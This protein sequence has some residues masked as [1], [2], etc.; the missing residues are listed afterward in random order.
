M[1]FFQQLLEN[2]TRKLKIFLTDLLWNRVWISRFKSIYCLT[3]K[4]RFYDTH[5]KQQELF[6]RVPRTVRRCIEPRTF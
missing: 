4:K 2:L 1:Q 3:F 5:E 6:P